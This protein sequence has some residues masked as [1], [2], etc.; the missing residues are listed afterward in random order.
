MLLLCPKLLEHLRLITREDEQEQ[1]KKLQQK[2]SEQEI[3]PRGSL[4]VCARKRPSFSTEQRKH[5]PL[6]ARGRETWDGDHQGWTQGKDGPPSDGISRQD[7]GREGRRETCQPGTSDAP[8]HFQAHAQAWHSYNS[9]WR[10]K[11]RGEPHHPCAR[12]QP[13]WGCHLHL[14]PPCLFF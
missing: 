12:T 5:V 9:T 2:S 3:T 4:C 7:R 6:A 1:N 14:P 10:S 13:W 8:L 11:Q